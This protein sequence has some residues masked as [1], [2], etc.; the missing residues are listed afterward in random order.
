MEGCP[1]LL[2]DARAEAVLAHEAMAATAAG[3][4]GQ[5]VGTVVP[6]QAAV[7]AAASPGSL[8]EEEKGLASQGR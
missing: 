1:V 5:T 4:V 2:Q 8:G 3:V 7:V 6:E